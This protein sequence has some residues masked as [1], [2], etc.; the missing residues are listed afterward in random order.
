ML[1]FFLFAALCYFSPLI[2][3]VYKDVAYL[4]SEEM[5]VKIYFVFLSTPF[6]RFASVQPFATFLKLL[7]KDMGVSRWAVRQPFHKAL[8]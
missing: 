3:L 6:V 5:F 7:R 8:L 1:V 4:R 2:T